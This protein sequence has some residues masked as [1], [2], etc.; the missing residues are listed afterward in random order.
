M[1]ITITNIPDVTKKNIDQSKQSIAEKIITNVYPLFDDIYQ[2][3]K[4][5]IN[6]LQEAI[7]L[8]KKSLSN[9]K[10]SIEEMMVHYRKA[11]KISNILD[12][13]NKLL[14]LGIAYDGSM[15]N[16]TVIL[17]KILDKLP[18]EQLNQ[19]LERTVEMINKRF[20]K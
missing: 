1:N 3:K 18:E 2:A 14:Q 6:S 15:K 20:S 17:L 11:K 13:V 4:S 12:R 19:Q 5:S 7:K 9:E 16:E 10:Q 8:K